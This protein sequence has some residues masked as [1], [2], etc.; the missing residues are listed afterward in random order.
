MCIRD[1]SIIAIHY[2][3]AVTWISSFNNQNLST[4]LYWNGSD[5]KGGF[6]EDGA[7][8]A[9]S[10]NP[11]WDSWA[12]FSLSRVNNTNTPG[13]QNQYAVFSGTDITGTGI[14][15]VVYDDQWNEADIITLPT[16]SI[17]RGFYVNNTTYAALSMR[18]G[19][20]FAKKFGGS[21]GNDPDWFKLTI[22]GKDESGAIL[23]T[24]DFYLADYRFTNNALDYIIDDWTWV[25]LTT[26]GPDVKTLHFTLSSSDTGPWGMNTPAFF[27]MDN[28]SF[29]PSFSG[30]S[31]SSSKWDAAVPGF[32]GPAGTGST[33]APN[34]V[35]PSFAGWA[36]AVALYS[37]A[38]GVASQ[39]TNASKALGPATGNNFDIVSLGD[40]NKTQITSGVAPG[41]ITLFFDSGIADKTGP[42]FVVFENG[43]VS[44]KKV[45]A[46]LGYVE[47]SSDGTNFARFPSVSLT[48][49]LVGAFGTIN[50]HNVYNLCGKHVNAYGQSWGT[51]FD[52]SDVACD[53]LVRSNLVDLA[54]IKYVR[55]VDIPGSGDFLDSFSPANPIFD[56][57]V[58]SGSGGVDLEAIGVINSPLHH[59]IFASSTKYGRITPAGI[60]D[61]IVAVPYGG[62]KTFN[63]I[64][65]DEHVIFDVLVNNISIGQTTN[66]TFVNVQNDQTIHAKFGCTLTIISTHGSPDPAA[67]THVLMP[68]VINASAGIS[69][70]TEGGTQWVCKGWVRTGSHPSSGTNTTTGIFSLTNNSTIVWLWETNYFLDTEASRGGLVI[71]ADGWHSAGS[72]VTSTAAAHNWYTFKGWSGDTEGN[73]NFII[74][75]NIMNKAKYIKANFYA[76]E[77]TNHVPVAWLQY[78]NLTNTPDVESLSDQDND[79]M[80][81]WE[82][83]LAGTD[84]TNKNSVF[85][86]IDT[87]YLN[88]SN[89]VKW[90]AGTNGSAIPFTILTRTNLFATWIEFITDLP[91]S[92]SG[93]NIFWFVP[94]HSNTFYRITVID[95][96]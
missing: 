36:T 31:T 44:G 57:W 65:D 69:T 85:E 83:F 91:R 70:I 8:F 39:W 28:L 54:S 94:S 43:F 95:K 34:T 66:Y 37:P 18:D 48:T 80:K 82:E 26:L 3:A 93:T 27:A 22:T 4:N 62:N 51:P 76:E 45:F 24:V 1:R 84:P 7:F 15:A 52:L 79:G 71:P 25:D 40:L 5:G 50:A 81:T 58:T 55:I 23:G 92:P 10:Y 19:D 49:N 46:E 2:T 33:N 75:T 72:I 67:G 88:G 77:A 38:P 17:I 21:S 60:P 29:V 74:M 53:P 32:V 68:A 30:P 35:N 20:M 14:Y 86:I 61:G 47:V 16:P 96:Y 89:Y 64:P 12:G 90:L 78:Y 87:G 6:V 59:R 42:D 13:Y 11:S 56:A 63:I 41:K 9:N 73:T